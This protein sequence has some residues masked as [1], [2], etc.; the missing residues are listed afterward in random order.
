MTST[1]ITSSSH[2]VKLTTGG[3]LAI[4]QTAQIGTGNLTLNV[5][6]NVTQGA[7]GIITAAGLQ[8]TGSGSV[9][10]DGAPHE[11][12]PAA[13]TFN[14]PLS[15][16][17]QNGLTVGVVGDV[18]SGMT[19]TGITSSSH[20]VKLTTGNGLTINEAA[21]IGTGN[22]TLNVTGNVTQGASGIITA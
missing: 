15:Y 19:S 9:H 17:D 1:G 10:L 5:T 22:L 21:Q 20:D 18:F 3:D 8:L 13:A 7:S 2:D 12:T 16:R 14:G 6:G 4:S 11:V